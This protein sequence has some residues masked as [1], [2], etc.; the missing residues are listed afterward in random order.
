MDTNAIIFS[1]VFGMIGMGFFIYGKKQQKGI[2]ML[3]GIALGIYPYF[4]SSFLLMVL[5]G[6]AL[7]AVP[8]YFR[9]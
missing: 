2:P 4:V 6:V 9:D 8:F 1:F 7:T 3:V 5:I